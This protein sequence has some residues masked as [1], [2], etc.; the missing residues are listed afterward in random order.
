[1]NHE[2][3]SQKK[4]AGRVEKVTIIDRTTKNGAI[5]IF[6]NNEVYVANGRNYRGKSCLVRFD[7]K[8]KR[9]TIATN[10]LTSKLEKGIEY[11][12]AP[13]Q[14]ILLGLW[15]EDMKKQDTI[16]KMYEI[17]YYFNPGRKDWCYYL[18]KNSTITEG[19][20]YVPKYSDPK[21]NGVTIT[22]IITK[23][24]PNPYQSCRLIIVEGIGQLDIFKEA[25]K[26]QN[27]VPIE[28]ERLV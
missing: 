27:L 25:I 12:L 10:F 4:L 18:T 19:R 8:Q 22:R 21:K 28:L 20:Y 26:N 2:T 14:Y 6:D 7:L 17:E 23:K 15:T 16:P 1:M 5:G 13:E 11:S 9:K 24:L 3:F